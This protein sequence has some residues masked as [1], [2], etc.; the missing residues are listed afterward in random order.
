MHYRR[1]FTLVEVCVVASILVT[2]AAIV[3][4]ATG[5][6]R[7]SARQSK[8]ASNLRQISLA[9]NLYSQDYGVY[10]ECPGYESLPLAP[11]RDASLLYPYIKAD[12]ILFCP[13]IPRAK[14]TGFNSSYQWN[15]S[16]R[17]D[18]KDPIDRKLWEQQITRVNQLGS[19][20]PIVICHIHDETYYLPREQQ[21]DP[22]LAGK[23]VVE[24]QLSGSIFK[25]R[26]NYSRNYYFTKRLR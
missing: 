23:F 15:L 18:E 20:A 24:L 1:A 5:P 12:A 14:V 3:F 4:I 9:L 22:K 10:E 21:F 16:P 26:R 11:F 13:N 19:K 7:E 17:G 25:G 2:L 6:M 8:C